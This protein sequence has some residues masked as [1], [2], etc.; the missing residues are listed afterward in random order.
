MAN[1][2]SL[3]FPLVQNPVRT[4]IV[5]EAYRIGEVVVEEM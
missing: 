3:A 4:V 1:R 2:W 5:R